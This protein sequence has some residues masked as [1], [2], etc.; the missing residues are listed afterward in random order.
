MKRY[1]IFH[2]HTSPSVETSNPSLSWEQCMHSFR[3]IYSIFLAP[4]GN[5]FNSC[6]QV[7]RCCK[8]SSDQSPLSN[9]SNAH[10]TLYMAE[11][12]VICPYFRWIESTEASC[13]LWWHN[14]LQ[15]VLLWLTNNITFTKSSI[16]KIA[17]RKYCS[18]DKAVLISSLKATFIF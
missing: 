18:Y 8:E 4:A 6:Q 1:W 3:G 9:R 12:L 15:N 11:K 13:A 7:L 5:N 14:E 10:W 17:F 16:E 2:C